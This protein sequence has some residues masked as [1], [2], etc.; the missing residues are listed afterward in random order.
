VLQ[1]EL[2]LQLLLQPS[3]LVRVLR[4]VSELSEEMRR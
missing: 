3:E 4:V 1:L 2:G